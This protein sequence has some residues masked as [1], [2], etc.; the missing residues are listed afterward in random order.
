MD[1]RDSVK[2]L[3]RRA[4]FGLPP[5]QM[6]A[7]IDRGFTAELDRLLDTS[8]LAEAV[9]A[10]PWDNELLPYD[11]MDAP[12]RRYAIGRWIDA[13]AMTE[14]PLV[15]RMTWLWHGHFVEPELFG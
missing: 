4:G 7:A 10:D 13:M 2:W 14:Q 11:P 3:H 12:S 15:D 5:A 9:A 6:G 8:A 1:E